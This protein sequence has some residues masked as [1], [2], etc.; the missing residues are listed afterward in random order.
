ME[1]KTEA[2][3]AEQTDEERLAELER[4]GIIRRGK[5]KLP[6][7]FTTRPLPRPRKSVL[8]ALLEDRHST[9]V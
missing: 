5:G 3:E 2:T 6:P 1:D 9:K 8:E 7:D 4:K